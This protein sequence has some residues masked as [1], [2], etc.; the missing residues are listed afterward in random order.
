M[1]FFDMSKMKSV[2]EKC[3]KFIVYIMVSWYFFDISIKIIV[4]YQK[5]VKK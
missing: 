2:T 5:S 4:L 1:V 3:L